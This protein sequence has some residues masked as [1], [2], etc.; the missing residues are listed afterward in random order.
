M[1]ALILIGTLFLGMNDA[2]A[3]KSKHTHRNQTAQVQVSFHWVWIKG[4]WSH[5]H[6]VK[7]RWSQRP[8]PHP[9]AHHHQM[10]WISGHYEGRGQHRHWVPGHWIR[11]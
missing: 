2:Y 11:M 8:G 7:P 9:Y 4:H 1:T 3:H 6:W 5:G 10:R